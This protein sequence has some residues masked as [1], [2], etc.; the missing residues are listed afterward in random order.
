MRNI[1]TLIGVAAPLAAL[2]LL[3]VPAAA[4][5]GAGR[6]VTLSTQQGSFFGSP[7]QG[8]WSATVANTAGNSNYA[9]GSVRGGGQ[10][11][12]FF[13]FDLR[14][15]TGRISAAT[16]RLDRGQ[17]SAPLRHRVSDVSTAPRT[18]SDTEGV[19]AAIYRDLGTGTVYG[20]YRIG[21]SRAGPLALVLNRAG[22]AA[23]NTGR[24]GFVSFGGSVLGVGDRAFAGTGQT[25]Q[26][27]LLTLSP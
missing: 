19:N 3:A 13:T 15:V 8:V 4:T 17:D 5:A 22:V 18:L 26:H 14:A 24:G 23:L 20:T 1:R 7:N 2:G 25:P 27:L 12:D 11:R 16:L 21:R 6:S 9:A 10:V